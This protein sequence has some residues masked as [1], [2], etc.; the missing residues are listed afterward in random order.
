MNETQRKLNKLKRIAL[1]TCLAIGTCM[2]SYY[3]FYPI[4][5]YLLI[6]GYAA[7]IEDLPKGK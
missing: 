7:G 4:A 1:W 5:E 2:V 3:V 6:S